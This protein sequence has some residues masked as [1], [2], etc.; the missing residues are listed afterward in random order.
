[1]KWILVICISFLTWNTNAQERKLLNLQNNVKLS[2]KEGKLF[3]QSPKGEGVYN[4]SAS[5]KSYINNKVQSFKSKSIVGEDSVIQ[6]VNPNKLL[7]NG[8]YY[9]LDLFLSDASFSK[10]KQLLVKLDVVKNE[11]ISTTN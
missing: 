3:Y 1:M 2:V 10:I 4:L 9:D 5:E 8:N 7:V 6:T 11:V